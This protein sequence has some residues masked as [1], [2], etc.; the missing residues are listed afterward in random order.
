LEKNLR[1]GLVADVMNLSSAAQWAEIIGLITILGAAVYSWFQIR[2]LKKVS[3]STAALSL[4]ELFQSPDFAAG[5]SLISYQPENLKNFEDFKEKDI[6]ES[7][8]VDIIN[9]GIND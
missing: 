3:K 9:R 8:K 5:L 2:E 1:L 7:Y 4:S 6:L